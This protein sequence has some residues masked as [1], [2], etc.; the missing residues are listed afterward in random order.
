MKQETRN[1]KF[2]CEFAG[3]VKKA[4]GYTMDCFYFGCIHQI[5]GDYPILNGGVDEEKTF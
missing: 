3:D 1:K 5:N 2:K 4:K